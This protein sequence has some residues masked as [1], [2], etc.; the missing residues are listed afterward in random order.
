MSYYAGQIL[1]CIDE[2]HPLYG[3]QVKISTPLDESEDGTPAISDIKT[4]K[5]LHLKIQQISVYQPIIN[6]INKKA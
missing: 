1:Y 5:P 3:K 4:G 6:S 2:S